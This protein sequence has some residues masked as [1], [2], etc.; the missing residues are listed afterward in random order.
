[1]EVT[2]K[3]K[4]HIVTLSDRHTEADIEIVQNDN[5]KSVKFKSFNTD[6][7]LCMNNGEFMQLL[8]ILQTIKEQL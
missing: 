2:T 8:K 1:M 4:R 3:H 6:Y 7:Q 5:F